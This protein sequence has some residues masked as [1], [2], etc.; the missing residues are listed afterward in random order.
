MSLGTTT[1]GHKSGHG[2]RQEIQKKMQAA[3]KKTGQKLSADRKDNERGYESKNVRAVPPSLNRGR[4][5]VDKKKLAEWKK[6][7]KKIDPTLEIEDLL[8]MIKNDLEETL[9]SIEQSN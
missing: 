2:K 6:R 5:S 8:K 4:H 1:G 9:Q 3:E 7:L